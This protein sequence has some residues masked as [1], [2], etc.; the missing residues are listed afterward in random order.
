MHK[1]LH[2]NRTKHHL[3]LLFG[4]LAMWDQG[5]A[6]LGHRYS[7]AKQAGPRTCSCSGSGLSGW[8][9]TPVGQ[10]RGCASQ[11]PVHK[12]RLPKH[13]PEPQPRCHA[14]RLSQL[15][16]NV[17]AATLK[18]HFKSLAAQLH[19]DVSGAHDAAERFAELRDEYVM[20]L[21]Q[22]RLAARSESLGTA[23]AILLG[24][25]AFLWGGTEDPLL[26]ALLVAIGGMITASIESFSFRR[27]PQSLRFLVP[28]P[29]RQLTGTSPAQLIRRLAVGSSYGER[30]SIYT[31]TSAAIEELMAQ[32]RPAPSTQLKRNAMASQGRHANVAGLAVQNARHAEEGQQQDAVSQA[33]MDLRSAATDEASLKRRFKQ[34]AAELHPDR[35]SAPDAAERFKLLVDE[36]LL[37]LLEAQVKARKQDLAGAWAI[38]AAAAAAL[39]SAESD[40]MLPA[41]LIGVG[42]AITLAAERDLPVLMQAA[43]RLLKAGSK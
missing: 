12:V 10:S 4:S 34:L 8:F 21:E 30:E 32:L 25:A 41:M 6:Y 20:R 3:L 29:P 43:Q 28:A 37:L 33:S 18:R 31:T 24:T 14:P 11:F 1:F 19:P 13:R 17:D 9:L 23:W 2:R 38:L 35:S 42:V 27:L 7:A 26:P 5:Q 39:W 15:P 22:Q 40:P 36:Y 16:S